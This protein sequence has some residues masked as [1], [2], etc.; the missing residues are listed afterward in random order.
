MN[1]EDWRRHAACRGQDTGQFYSYES[2]ARAPIPSTLDQLCR[3]C[4][5]VSPCLSHAVTYE[6]YGW[7]AGTTAK[8]RDELRHTLG[9][10]L[11]RVNDK[12]NEMGLDEHQDTELSVAVDP[13]THDQVGG[14]SPR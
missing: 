8:D 3:G 1:L 9:I 5:V 6:A 14:D 13:A 10:R 2:D 11:R 12:S 7:W 4:V